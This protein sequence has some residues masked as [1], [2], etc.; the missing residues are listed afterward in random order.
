M[1]DPKDCPDRLFKLL[2]EKTDKDKKEIIG[3]IRE[4]QDKN[5][6]MFAGLNHENKVQWAAIAIVFIGVLLILGTIL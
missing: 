6:E 2:K 3:V 1:I 4:N 5:Y